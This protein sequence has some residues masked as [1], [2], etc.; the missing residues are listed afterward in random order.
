MEEAKS[1]DDEDYLDGIASGVNK[2]YN[3]LIP[4]L[5]FQK[6][7]SENFSCKHCHEEFRGGRSILVDKIGFASNVFWA[8]PNKDYAS[9]AFILA[10]T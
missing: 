6:N 5:S 10:P 3:L 7:I 1:D 4:Q 2:N 8:C 9:S